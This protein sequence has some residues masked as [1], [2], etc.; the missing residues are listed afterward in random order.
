MTVQ[1]GDGDVRTIK[2]K[3]YRTQPQTRDY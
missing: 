2:A 3:H 1:T